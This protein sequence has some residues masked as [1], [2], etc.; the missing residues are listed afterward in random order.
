MIQTEDTQ[1][2]LPQPDIAND[3]LKI[4]GARLEEKGQFDGKWLD[5]R[6]PLQKAYVLANGHVINQDPHQYFTITESAEQELI[7]ATNELHL[8]YLHAH[9]QGAERR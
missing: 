5:E 8:M 1:Y 4:R 3:S 7:K 6:D 2:S 9:R